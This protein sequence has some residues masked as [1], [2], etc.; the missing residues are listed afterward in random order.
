MDEWPIMETQNLQK[1]YCFTPVK[2]LSIYSLS[3]IATF[4]SLKQQYW[5]LSGEWTLVDKR[6]DRIGDS[7]SGQRKNGLISTDPVS[8]ESSIPFFIFF[9]DQ[10]LAGVTNQQLAYLRTLL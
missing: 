4:M 10:F 5:Q 1:M 9:V 3:I 2:Y 7:Q 8:L 6:T